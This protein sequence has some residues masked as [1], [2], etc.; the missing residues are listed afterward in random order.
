[1]C[2]VSENFRFLLAEQGPGGKMCILERAKILEISPY[3]EAKNA[4]TSYFLP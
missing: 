3:Q 4:Q 1:M 2:P